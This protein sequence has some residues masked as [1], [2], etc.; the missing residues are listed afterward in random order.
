MMLIL[1][2]FFKNQYTKLYVPVV[3]LLSAKNNQ[4]QPKLL[5]KGD[6]R[7]FLLNLI[8]GGGGEGVGQNKL[9]GWN[10]KKSVNF[11]NE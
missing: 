7:R 2:L 6:F 3:T 8:D 9:G 11:G 5:S 10:F 1:I 4:N